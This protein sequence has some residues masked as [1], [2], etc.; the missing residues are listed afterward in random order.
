MQKKNF[1]DFIGYKTSQHN[2]IKMCTQEEKDRHTQ[3]Y[4]TGRIV[5]NFLCYS[6]S[7]TL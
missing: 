6:F 4:D 1:K 3:N 5:T 7:H 2:Q